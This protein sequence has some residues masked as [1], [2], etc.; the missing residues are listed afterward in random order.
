MLTPSA[1][2]DL[3]GFKHRALLEGVRYVWEAL[4]GLEA[5]IAEALRPEIQGTVIAGAW[6]GEDVFIGKGT[7]VEPGALVR[8]PAIIGE[9]CEIR[10]GC[11]VRGHVL[12]GDGAVLGHCSELKWAI[13]LNQARAPHFNYVGDSILG[14][15]VNLGAGSICANV[16]LT[17]EEIGV[18]VNSTNYATGLAK[19][20]A[21]VGDHVQI[22]CNTVLNPGTLVGK[23]SVVYPNASLRGYYPP[24]S[25]IKTREKI[26]VVERRSRG[27]DEEGCC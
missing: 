10:Q 20:G 12:V 4:G 2:F 7:I 19:F 3:E 5:Y 14:C 1:F 9:N 11:Y 22:G 6:V 26:E 15:N 23:H 21:V 17:G 18:T 27:T 24:Y 16:K 13:L 8:G 25:V